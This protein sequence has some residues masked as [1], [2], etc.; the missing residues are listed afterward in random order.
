M[1][2]KSA[3][4]GLLFVVGVFVAFYVFVLVPMGYSF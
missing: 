2:D 1:F 3:L 4:F